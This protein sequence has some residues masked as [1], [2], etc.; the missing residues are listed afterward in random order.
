MEKRNRIIYWIATCWLAL[1]M[2]STGI[3]QILKLPKGAGAADSLHSLGYPAYMLSILGISKLLGVVVLLVPKFPLLKEWAYTGF[4]FMMSG[5]ICS[6]LIVGNGASDIFP[7]LLLLVLTL[8]SW[9]FRP[10]N[11]RIAM[12]P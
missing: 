6:H 10:A 5:A 1:G 3:V 12:N 2:I 8:L 7:A 11:R 4:F 9:Y